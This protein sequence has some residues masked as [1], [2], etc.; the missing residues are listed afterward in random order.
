MNIVFD[1]RFLAKSYAPMQ[2][3]PEALFR[4]KIIEKYFVLRQ[5]GLNEKETL[6]ILEVKRSTF[7]RWKKLYNKWNKK[8]AGL[9]NK[10]RRPLN[11][12]KSKVI[13][14]D[15]VS[16]ILAIRQEFPMFGK[17]KITNLLQRKGV[18]ISESTVGRILKD[19]IKR[20][21]I[22]PV[23]LLKG[24]RINYRRA[25][26]KRYAQRWKFQRAQEL[27]EMIQID[28]MSVSVNLDFAIKEFRAI[29][30][31]SRIVISK[32][33]FKATARN[34]KDFLKYLKEKLPFAVKSIQVDGGSEFMSEFEQYCEKQEI[35]LFVLPPKSPKYNGKIERA[36]GTYRYEFYESYEMPHTMEELRPMIEDFEYHYNYKRPHAALN[37]LTPM[38]FYATIKRKVA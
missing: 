12:R 10:S 22:Y 16:Q 17:A 36:N 13:S 19:L 15:L 5:Q 34:A 31:I 6:D 11:F 18:N 35:E 30:P 9:E 23:P 1:P 25:I 24:K 3:T 2:T 33:Y 37:Y 7:Y 4:L 28:H 20:K 26:N 8:S 38:E 27:G 32:Q 14:H 29:C 21:K